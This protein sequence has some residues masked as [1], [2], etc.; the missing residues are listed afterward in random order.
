M[1]VDNIN[2]LDTTNKIPQNVGGSFKTIKDFFDGIVEPNLLNEEILKS[3][4]N[5][6]FEYINDEK[7]ILVLRKYS[8]H[9]INGEWSTRRGMLTKY[10]NKSY[11]GVDNYFAHII[12]ALANKGY[13]PKYI[14]FKTS[15]INRTL[16]L[17]F[18]R[19][20]RIERIKSAY[21]SVKFNNVGINNNNWKLS[22]V[23][24]V[25]SMY[26]DQIAI[27]N[28][29][30][31]NTNNE[32]WVLQNDDNYFARNIKRD[33]SLSEI[34]FLNAHFL[35][36]CNPMNHFLSP[37]INYH[38]YKFGNDVGEDINVLTYILK[39]FELKYGEIFSKFLELAEF[40][41]KDN[42]SLDEIGEIEIDLKIFSQKKQHSIKSNKK[43]VIKKN[44][45]IKKKIEL[46]EE[47]LFGM[48]FSYVNIGLSFRDIEKFILEIDSKARGGGFIAKKELN[49]MGITSKL[50]S[51]ITTKQDLLEYI[52]NSKGVLKKTLEDFLE[53]VDNNSAIDFIH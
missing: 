35:R 33:M 7:S 46:S 30:F 25:N 44:L 19:K 47:K 24:P 23:L 5:L 16:P 1:I 18:N 3:W 37:K 6:L 52:H 49:N 50:K 14:D 53:W 29:N 12:F 2:N 34:K 43:I 22:H 13:I 26:N 38:K 39:K 28:N 17:R 36:L 42:R 21:P 41:I 8:S 4:A 11:V 45:T 20:T 31:P 32:D 51:K 10:N 9:K 27:F 40:V 48:I 15:F